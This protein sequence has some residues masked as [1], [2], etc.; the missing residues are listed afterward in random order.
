MEDELI[1]TEQQAVSGYVKQR[2]V[3]QKKCAVCGT[4][5]EGT[6]RQKYCGHT[7][8]VRAWDAAHAEERRER[9]RASYQRRKAGGEET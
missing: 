9:Q 1:R 2:K 4:D 8:A 3:F 7:C 6:A 5:Y